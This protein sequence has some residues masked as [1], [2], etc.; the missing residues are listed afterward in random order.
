[1]IVGVIIVLASLGALAVQVIPF[2]HQEQVA[3]I[4]PITAT[5]DKQSYIFIP[6]FAAVIGILVG[7]GL[8]FAGRRGS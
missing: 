6:P 4:G 7:G 2:H 3:K 1:M 8:I 5:E